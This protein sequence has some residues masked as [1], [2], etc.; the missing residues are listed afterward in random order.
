MATPRKK[1]SNKDG[2]N[3]LYKQ[4]SGMVYYKRLA[5]DAKVNPFFGTLYNNAISSLS[6]AQSFATSNLPHIASSLKIQA[7][8]ELDKEL[9]A[10]EEAWGVS[11]TSEQLKSQTFYKDLIEAINMVIQSKEVYERNMA[12]MKY[13]GQEQDSSLAKIDISQMF[14]SYF[15]SYWKDGGQATMTQAIRKELQAWRDLDAYSV[16]K[17]IDSELPELI[18][19]TLIRMLESKPFD[20]RWSAQEAKDA[21]ADWQSSIDAGTNPYIKL[22]DEL[23]QAGGNLNNNPLLKK[24]WQEMGFDK[25]KENMLKEINKLDRPKK[26]KKNAEKILNKGIGKITGSAS[27]MGNL[28]EVVLT[29]LASTVNANTPN[30]NVVHSGG[31]NKQKPDLVFFYRANPTAYLNNQQAL[32]AD[33]DLRQKAKNSVR[34]QNVM[35][36]TAL[37][38]Y[39]SGENPITQKGFNFIAY[40]NAKT[41]SL[42]KNFSGFKG[43]T[44]LSMDTLSNI[45]VRDTNISARGANALI[46]QL[47]QFTKGAVGDGK[48]PGPILDSF[49][50]VIAS[51]LFDDYATLCSGLIPEGHNALHFFA[52]EGIYVPLSFFL[53]KVSEAIEMCSNEVD[54]FFKFSLLTG[55][56]KYGSLPLEDFEPGMWTEQREEAMTQTRISLIF[57]RNFQELMR[58]L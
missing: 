27:I 15:A 30:L 56:I 19:K 16:A 21:N 7:S 17:A 5:E 29:A 10:L 51:F 49:A 22:A 1:L 52:L 38:R 32:L 44:N 14:G 4:S 55:T 31:I 6:N 40:V 26:V 47:V 46:S 43:E 37:G 53:N 50:E 20:A 41:Y 12:R 25:M 39:M 48:D 28:A 45:L 54:S 8:N 23:R 2:S 58:A 33:E 57:L 18:N 24:V 34:M 35:A 9:M 42:G 36:S 11:F 3:V 13:K